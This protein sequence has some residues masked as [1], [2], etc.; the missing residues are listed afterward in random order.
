MR[1]GSS[2]T[3]REK[4]MGVATHLFL[5]RM[6]SAFLLAIVLAVGFLL[7]ESPHRALADT[8]DV[9]NNVSVSANSGGNTAPAGTVVN[10]TSTASVHIEQTINGVPQ[11]P[12]DITT[13]SPSVSVDLQ[14]HAN[15]N[16]VTS[17]VHISTKLKTKPIA[18]ASYSPASASTSTSSPSTT[19]PTSTSV[20][21]NLFT[22]IASIAKSIQQTFVSFFKLFT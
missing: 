14:T 6:F 7:Q 12:V 8:A 1:C 11:T 17:T 22:T 13:T 4:E 3:S 18:P 21:A 19:T 2:K 5:R 16:Q 20:S 9:E 10:G 15:Q